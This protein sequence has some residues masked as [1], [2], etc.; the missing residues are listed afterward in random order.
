MTTSQQQ[1]DSALRRWQ[2]LPEITPSERIAALMAECLLPP[3]SHDTKYQDTLDA[4]S[5]EMAMS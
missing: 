4:V 2:E 5:A 3:L 1:A